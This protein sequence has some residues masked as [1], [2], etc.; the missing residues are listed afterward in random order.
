MSVYNAQLIILLESFIKY[1]YIIVFHMVL[2]RYWFFFFKQKTA[3]EM[4]ISDWSSDVC[5]SDLLRKRSATIATPAKRLSPIV[6]RSIGYQPFGACSPVPRT[7]T[8][9]AAK[10]LFAIVT[11]SAK[12]PGAMQMPSRRPGRTSVVQG[13]GV[14]VRVETGGCRIIKKKNTKQIFMN[15]IND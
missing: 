12:V 15:N 8:P 11:S 13:K 2:V 5:S 9:I 4:R 10:S 6:S 7:T 1:F 14:S 3:Y